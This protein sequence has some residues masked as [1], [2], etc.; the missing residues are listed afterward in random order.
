MPASLGPCSSAT[1]SDPAIHRCS[2]GNAQQ[3]QA[4]CKAVHLFADVPSA[5]QEIFDGTLGRARGPKGA[6]GWRGSSCTRALS[7]CNAPARASD[8]LRRHFLGPN[9]ETSTAAE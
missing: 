8:A 1:L 4:F 3:L 6:A 9:R 2:T 7:S 5:R